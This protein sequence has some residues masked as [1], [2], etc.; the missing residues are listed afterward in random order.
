MSYLVRPLVGVRRRSESAEYPAVSY[1]QAVA[2]AR[3]HGLDAIITHEGEL[4]GTWSP[5]T[6]EQR[7]KP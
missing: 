1:E 7:G 2:L 6:G 3:V 4:V 5:K